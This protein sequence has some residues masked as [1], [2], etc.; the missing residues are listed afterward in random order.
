MMTSERRDYDT[1]LALKMKEGRPSVMKFRWFLGAGKGNGTGSSLELAGG[2]RSTD[3][4]ILSPVKM[5][6]TS[7]NIK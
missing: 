6:L 2:N 4:L 5:M 1:S 7:R 3:F